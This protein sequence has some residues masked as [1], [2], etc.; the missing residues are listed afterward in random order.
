MQLTLDAWPDGFAGLAFDT[1]I[2]SSEHTGSGFE[3]RDNVIMNNRGRGMLVKAG[4]GV[5]EGNTIIRPTFWPV[6]V[7]AQC[8]LSDDSGYLS[9][10]PCLERSHQNGGKKLQDRA[11]WRAAM[12]RLLQST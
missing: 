12:E 1:L 7:T 5:M 3:L 6:Q 9:H 11:G 4:N 10:E 2:S 8:P